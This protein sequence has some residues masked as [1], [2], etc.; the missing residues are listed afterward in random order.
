MINYKKRVNSSDLEEELK[1]ISK[2]VEELKLP[3]GFLEFVIYVFSEISANI[4]EHS[5]AKSTII[6]I[7]INKD[8]LISFS[9]NGIGLRK[10]YL[11]KEIYP[12]DDRAAIEF[13][14]GGLS[15]KGSQERGFGL[16]SIKK[17]TSNLEGEMIIKSGSIEAVIKKNQVNFNNLV[18]E[19]KGVNIIIK[20]KVKELDF[21][22]AIE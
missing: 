8:C 19:K 1:T 21:Y 13:A 2:K 12:K 6:E 16:Y 11:L 3:K 17:L 22:N 4:K 15:T 10:S 5:E 18:E 9:D 7:K 20:T 14:L